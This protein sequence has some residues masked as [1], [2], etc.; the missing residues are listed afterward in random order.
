MNEQEAL[1][2][3]ADY[4]ERFGPMRAVETLASKTG[5]SRNT[6]YGWHRRQSIPQWRLAAFSLL[7]PKRK[8][9]A[10]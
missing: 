10:A 1:A 9:K 2:T 5:V 3:I 6:I 7:K 4:I 8:R